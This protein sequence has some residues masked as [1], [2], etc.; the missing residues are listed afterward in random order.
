MLLN[1]V[2]KFF[3]LNLTFNSLIF[4][5]AKLWW[6]QICLFL[7]MPKNNIEPWFIASATAKHWFYSLT[8]IFIILNNKS[9]WFPLLLELFGFKN[10]QQMQLEF[11]IIC[12]VVVVVVA[13]CHA[14][15]FLKNRCRYVTVLSND[16]L[17]WTHYY[18]WTRIRCLLY[19]RRYD[20][21]SASIWN[22]NKSKEVRKHL[23]HYF[24]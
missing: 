23:I 6:N 24:R 1:L 4:R 12:V 11:V 21:N 16:Y 5:I 13:H 10:A 20:L 7:F 22:L 18:R 3:Q 2:I 19:I 17:V 15:I 14:Y 8:V 9:A